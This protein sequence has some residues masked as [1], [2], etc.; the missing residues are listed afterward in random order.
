[1]NRT[2][3]LLLLALA[4]L[5]CAQSRASDDSFLDAEKMKAALHTATPQEGGFIE[6]V[7]ARVEAGKLPLDLVQSTFL[8]AIKKPRKKFYYFK[9]G[10]IARA[11]KRGID[12]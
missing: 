6:Y 10:L 11:K 4:L 9:Y 7:V 1:M 8:W 3:P 12:L 5:C 2:V